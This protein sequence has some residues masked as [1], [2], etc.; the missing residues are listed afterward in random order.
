MACGTVRHRGGVAS[1]SQHP[2]NSRDERSHR[3]LGDSDHHTAVSRD[4]RRL[5]ATLF[6]RSRAGADCDQRTD[7]AARGRAGRCD[8]ARRARGAAATVI[9]GGS[10]AA[11][12]HTHS[13]RRPATRGASA[14][15]SSAC[16]R[17]KTFVF[18]SGGAPRWLRRGPDLYLAL[19]RH[20]RQLRRA[21][22]PA[23]WQLDE[24]KPTLVH[25][26]PRSEK[27]YAGEWD[28]ARTVTIELDDALGV[29]PGRAFANA[30]DDD[31]TGKIVLDALLA[32][33]KVR[34]ATGEA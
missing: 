11:S 29:L 28:A 6:R 23:G 26:V 4:S 8:D 15:S 22:P 19:A 1:P 18:V 16:E 33:R 25:L 34:N 13:R 3:H 32:P 2:P 17:L 21:C 24:A 7:R 20:L 9:R 14:T 10:R 12:R 5:C 30:F 27:P 31:A